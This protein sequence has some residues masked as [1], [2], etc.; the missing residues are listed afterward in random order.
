MEPNAEFAEGR[1]GAARCER[2]MTAIARYS[3]AMKFAER[4]AVLYGVALPAGETY[5]RW[6]TKPY[7]PALVDDYFIAAFLLLGLWMWKREPRRGRAA[8]AAAWGF[9]CGMGYA[10]F[11]GHLRVIDQPDPGRVPQV[12]L[13]V[14]IGAGWV[15]AIAATVQ[16]LRPGEPDAA[17]RA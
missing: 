11:F 14:I 7:L 8:F 10:S 16:V 1:K 17:A 9:T 2:D 13:T 6:G 12:W 3:A 15:L 5:R 4:L